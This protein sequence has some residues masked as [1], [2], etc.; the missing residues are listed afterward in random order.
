VV[1]RVNT[2][3]ST[4]DRG[5]FVQ[6]LDLSRIPNQDLAIMPTK[7]SGKPPP[8]DITVPNRPNED[9]EVTDQTEDTF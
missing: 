5:L 1:Y 7:S 9:T 2:L 3:E 4:F 8:D 6:T